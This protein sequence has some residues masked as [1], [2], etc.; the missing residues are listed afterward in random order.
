MNEEFFAECAKLGFSDEEAE[1]LL[2]IRNRG[3]MYLWEME[4]VSELNKRL[5]NAN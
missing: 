3:V 4:L 2:D 1:K 5:Q